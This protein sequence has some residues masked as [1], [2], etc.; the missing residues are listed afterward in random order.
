MRITRE[1]SWAMGHRLQRHQGL[2]RNPHGHNYVAVVTVAGPVQTGPTSEAGMVMDYA[3][4][5]TLVKQVLD[6]WDHAFMVEES[7]PFRRALREGDSMSE[8]PWKIVVVPW[9][10]TAENIAQELARK[11]VCPPNVHVAAVR[12]Y[13]TARSWAEGTVLP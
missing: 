5:D 8:E 4:L 10:P 11:I 9:P 6:P 13:E 12:I 1:Y 7:D 2:C 3:R